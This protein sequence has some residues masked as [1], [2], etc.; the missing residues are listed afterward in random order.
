MRESLGK[1]KMLWELFTVSSVKFSS[2]HCF[3]SSIET[4]ITYFLFLLEN[5]AT[6]K[7]KKNNY[8]TFNTQNVNLFVPSLCQ[9][10]V[11]V[12]CFY[13]VTEMCKHKLHVGLLKIPVWE[14]SVW[15][16]YLRSYCTIPVK[17]GQFWKLF[18]LH[19]IE[20]MRYS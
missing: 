7:K 8:F 18:F 17:Q 19:F 3:Y 15:N 9:Q 4:H 10:L 12:L 1:L 11:V 14:I 2:F 6:T 5:T 16:R 20:N 13:W